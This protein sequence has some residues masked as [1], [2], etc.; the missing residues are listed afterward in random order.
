MLC[1]RCQRSGLC[2]CRPTREDPPSTDI[3]SSFHTVW[4]V[5]AI[6]AGNI[7]ILAAKENAK[8]GLAFRQFRL[9]AKYPAARVQKPEASGTRRT[10]EVE[11]HEDTK[12]VDAPSSTPTLQGV[13]GRAENKGVRKKLYS[14]Y[15]RHEQSYRRQPDVT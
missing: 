3:D 1:R 5:V 8:R 15:R 6:D 14:K 4:I 11:L 2:D 10:A 12:T 13:F 7:H 9:R